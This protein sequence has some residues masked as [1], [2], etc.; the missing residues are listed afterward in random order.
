MLKY[1]QIYQII[2][3]KGERYIGSTSRVYL[4][5][6]MAEYKYSYLQKNKGYRKINGC[7]S[8][9]VS[10]DESAR[11][12]LIQKFPCANKQELYEREQFYLDSMKDIVIVKRAIR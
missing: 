10:Y 1:A 2:N 9:K 4:C 12:E 6:R 7:S 3:S 8:S 11:I 5:Q